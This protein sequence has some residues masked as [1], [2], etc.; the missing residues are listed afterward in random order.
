M[1]MAIGLATAGG[2]AIE[3]PPLARFLFGT[4]RAAPLWAALRV[5]IGYRWLTRGRPAPAGS[6]AAPGGAH[7]HVR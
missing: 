7:A 2:T 4:L 6:A 5:S 3:D 1:T